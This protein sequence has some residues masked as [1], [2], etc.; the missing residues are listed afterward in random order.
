MKFLILITINFFLIV[1]VFSNLNEKKEK[2]FKLECTN[3][4]KMRKNVQGFFLTEIKYNGKIVCPRIA[5][6][7][8]IGV[9]RKKIKVEVVEWG[10]G[11]NKKDIKK[12]EIDK[13]SLNRINKLNNREIENIENKR[14]DDLSE[15]L[16]KKM[17][18]PQD[19]HYLLNKVKKVYL[20]N[21]GY[22]EAV[23]SDNII[24]VYI[25][26]G[27]FIMGNDYQGED[28]EPEHKVYL[29]GY[30]IS[31]YE[32]SSTQ[33]VIFNEKTN[34]IIKDN[35]FFYRS[36]L[37]ATNIS[38]NDSKKFCKWLSKTIGLNFDLP[39]EAQWEKAARGS[40]EFR[41]YPWGNT[42]PGKSDQKLANFE[43]KDDGFKYLAPVK[44]FENG[45]SQFGV[46]NMSGNVS[47]WVR[48]WYDD[49]FY[50]RNINK[51]PKGPGTGKF[52]VIRGGSYIDFDFSIR[53][54]ARDKMLP[55]TKDCYIGFRIVL[56]N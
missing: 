12:Y 14:K 41:N 48:D 36:N 10:Q 1:N 45:S 6:F 25:P 42:E 28:E 40:R 20:N 35:D 44:S 49:N 23:F 47:E 19:Y 5:K 4:I 31:K 52:K 54:S 51:N 32:I 7:R 22:W 2:F 11:W 56:E 13:N 34:Y 27:N 37:P 33:F 8:I 50:S 21:K 18:F 16:I 53:V 39:T 3:T 24:M 17:G 46:I 29:P 43:S 30:W 55:N 9:E 15:T 26:K 38:W